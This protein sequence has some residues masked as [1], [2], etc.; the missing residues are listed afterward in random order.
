MGVKGFKEFL[1]VGFT[2]FREFL[3]VSRGFRW[4]LRGLGIF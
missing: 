2:G 4:V 1:K 3:K